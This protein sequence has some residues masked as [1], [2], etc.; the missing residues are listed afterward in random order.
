MTPPT[1][2]ALEEQRA[3]YAPVVPDP[4]DLEGWASDD[5]LDAHGRL[6][7]S[8]AKVRHVAGVLLWGARQVLKDG[9]YGEH[10]QAV[11][12]LYEVEPDTLYRWR[13]SAEQSD[14]LP[15]ADARSAGRRA[16]LEQGVGRSSD[17]S[18]SHES[19]P[20]PTPPPERVKPSEVLPPAQNGRIEGRVAPTAP[21]GRPP[22]HEQPT[23]PGAEAWGTVAKMTI[24]DLAG[25]P[26]EELKAMQR[27]IAEALRLADPGPRRLAPAGSRQQVEPRF[28]DKDR[29]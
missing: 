15:P 28:K 21:P 11:A 19:D 23:L 16:A 8:F 26:V 14:G 5:F 29:R 2:R 20:R 1:S 3:A 4:G 7:A 13:R 17:S 10:V 18:G 25:L 24:L 6:V 12:E 27:K 22:R 9:E